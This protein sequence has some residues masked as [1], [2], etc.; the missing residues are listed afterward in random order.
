MVSAY[1]S[2]VKALEVKPGIVYYHFHMSA[3]FMLRILQPVIAGGFY[4]KDSFLGF[5]VLGQ[6]VLEI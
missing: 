2:A 5:L 4:I 6:I 1:R 3:G